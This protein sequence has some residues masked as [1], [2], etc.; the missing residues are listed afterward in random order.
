ME[1][2]QDALGAS[3]PRARLHSSVSFL[4]DT[5]IPSLHRSSSC[6]VMRMQCTSCG[7]SEKD[8]GEEKRGRDRVGAVW[9][10]LMRMHCI[11]LRQTPPACMML[12]V[13]FSTSENSDR[14]RLVAR[15]E[16][17]GQRGRR[18]L[19]AGQAIHLLRRQQ[20]RHQN[21]DRGRWTD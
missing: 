20:T 15:H 14:S 1:P 5:P 10:D 8:E 6:G 19:L 7:R 18:P 11:S 16:M 17:E 13:P 4:R 2:S 12:V 3:L 21:G 9:D